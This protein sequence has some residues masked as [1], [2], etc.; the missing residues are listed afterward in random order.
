MTTIAYR[1]G[2]IAADSCVSLEDEGSGDWQGRCVKL[3]KFPDM[4]VGLQGE[5]T[6]GMVFLDWLRGGKRNR[7]LEDRIVASGASF[8]AVVLTRKGLFTYDHWCRPELCTTEF[9]A[10]GSGVKAALGAMHAGASARKAVEIACAI[11]PYTKPPV[12]SFYITQLEKHRK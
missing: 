2:T 7:R 10:V 9:Y 5:S 4:I 11:D 12:M 3:F 6:P 8:E 1:D